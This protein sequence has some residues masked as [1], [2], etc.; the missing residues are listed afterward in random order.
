MSSKARSVAAGLIALAIV[1][2]VALVFYLVETGHI[3]PGK[4]LCVACHRA[5][6]KAQV[7]T[8]ISPN[9]AELPSCCPR[10]GLRYTIENK[11]QSAQATDF[12]TGKSISPERAYYLE[13]SSIME[14]CSNT[15]L[16]TET[17]LVCDVHYD[18]CL[19][20]LVAFSKLEDAEEY[21]NNQGGHIINFA[22]ARASV[23]RQLGRE[24]VKE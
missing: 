4:P 16:R 6:H 10:C 13:G 9:G 1:V 22:E 14:C 19:P 5:L 23:A 12:K 2:A 11:A 15:P 20:S 17:G 8:V 21:R 18:R 7:Y 3:A 24:G